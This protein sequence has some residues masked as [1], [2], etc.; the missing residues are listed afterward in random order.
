MKPQFKQLAND[1]GIQLNI[2]LL[3]E[4][5]EEFA[6]AIV[7]MCAQVG[8]GASYSECAQHV[9]TTIKEHFGVN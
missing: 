6:E 4:Q 9:Y 8:Y 3:E 2:T 5:L 7:E 1:L